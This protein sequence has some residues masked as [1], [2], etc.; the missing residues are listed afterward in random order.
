MQESKT[1]EQVRYME[2]NAVPNTDGQ[3][4]A[5][6]ESS[7]M[8]SPCCSQRVSSRSGGEFL[9]GTIPQGEVTL[10][11]LPLP[12]SLPTLLGGPPQ[13]EALRALAHKAQ[14]TPPGDSSQ[15][16][17]VTKLQG[18][19]QA[20]NQILIRLPKYETAVFAAS[21]IAKHR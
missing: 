4:V 14:P 21:K 11:P 10:S 7:P 1:E 16:L 2:A 12:L 15:L 3:A 13:W 9:K 18:K 8:R 5:E 6:K 19:A 20:E 17:S